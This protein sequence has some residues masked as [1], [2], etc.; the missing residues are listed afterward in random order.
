MG[1]MQSHCLESLSFHV[2][3]MT[4][5]KLQCIDLP[6]TSRYIMFTLPTFIHALHQLRT[7][8]R[9]N[10]MRFFKPHLHLMLMLRGSHWNV[11]TIFCVPL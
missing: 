4:H 1:I 6:L 11:L 9:L 5:K 2:E 8:C 3:R 7:L 10:C